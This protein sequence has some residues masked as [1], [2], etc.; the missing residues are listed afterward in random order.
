MD[1]LT[2]QSAAPTAPLQGS[3][4][5]LSRL[6]RQLPCEGSLITS[7]L[8]EVDFAAGKRRRGCRTRFNPSVTFGDSPVC[9]ARWMSSATARLRPPPTA[10]HTAPALASATGGG[11]ARGPCEGSLGTGGHEVRPYEGDG[12]TVVGGTGGMGGGCRRGQKKERVDRSFFVGVRPYRW[13][14]RRAWFRSNPA[15]SPTPWGR[16]Y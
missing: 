9:G 10:A 4:E 5:P 8:G 2:P 13:L 12:G 3:L 11:Q 6:R 14:C 16:A 15:C 7:P 1:G